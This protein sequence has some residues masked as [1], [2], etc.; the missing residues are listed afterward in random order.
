MK[1]KIAVLVLLSLIVVLLFFDIRVKRFRVC[2][3]VTNLDEY[4]I[5]WATNNTLIAWNF[6]AVCEL[7]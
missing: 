6:N 4:S 7:K 1:F 3:D 5:T 2:S